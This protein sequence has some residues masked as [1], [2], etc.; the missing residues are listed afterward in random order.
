[1]RLGRR[2]LGIEEGDEEETVDEEGADEVNLNKLAH[3]GT[4]VC[5]LLLAT[6][7]DGFAS[8]PVLLRLGQS[9]GNDYDRVADKGEG[10]G[11]R[12]PFKDALLGVRDIIVDQ[13][14]DEVAGR[15]GGRKR[16]SPRAGCGRFGDIRIR[17]RSGNAANGEG[18][19]KE[20]EH[21]DGIGI[22]QDGD[23]VAHRAGIGPSLVVVVAVGGGE[24]ALEQRTG[25]DGASLH[26]NVRP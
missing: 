6:Y 5:L 8:P 19:Q 13:L 17:F 20:D 15:I 7:H 10:R 11:Q 21:N 12:D 26:G 14:L 16:L 4:W 1:M 9:V 24:V 23:G 2:W 18:S 25:H 22:L 3:G